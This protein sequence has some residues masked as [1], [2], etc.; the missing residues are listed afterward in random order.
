MLAWLSHLAVHPP[1]GLGGGGADVHL[2]G[3]VWCMCYAWLH[4]DAMGSKCL[5]REGVLCLPALLQRVLTKR[6]G[7]QE[8]ACPCCKACRQESF[9]RERIVEWDIAMSLACRAASLRDGGDDGDHF[10]TAVSSPYP[11]AAA[12]E[13]PASSAFLWWRFVMKQGVLLPLHVGEMRL[14]L[15]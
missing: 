5:M 7:C 6:F 10:S 4:T 14:Q 12:A 1:G 13:P 3:D 11:H 8:C 2:R 15:W 9:L